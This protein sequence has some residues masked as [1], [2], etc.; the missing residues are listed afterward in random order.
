MGVCSM[1]DYE[2][3]QKNQWENYFFN[4]KKCDFE[5]IS[6][7]VVNVEKDYTNTLKKEVLGNMSYLDIKHNFYDKFFPEYIP[8]A[9]PKKPTMM[10]WAKNL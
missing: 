1:K 4:Y 2:E 6:Y 5:H 7:Y 3:W 9:R 8:K 10:D